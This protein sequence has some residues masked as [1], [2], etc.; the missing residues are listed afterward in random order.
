MEVLTLQV[1]VSLMLVV[2]S[3][4]LFAYSVHKRDYEHVDRLALLPIADD[5]AARA[6]PEESHVH[7]R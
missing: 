7:D 6:A 1:F 5:D 3:V 4:I 2:G